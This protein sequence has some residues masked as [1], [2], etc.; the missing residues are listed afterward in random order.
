MGGVESLFFFFLED[1]VPCSSSVS[2]SEP[3]ILFLEAFGLVWISGSDVVSP[4]SRAFFFSFFGFGIV[5][6]LSI[7]T[8]PLLGSEPDA[9]GVSRAF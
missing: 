2:E 5:P 9:T 7:L 4:D 3:S 8:I 1:L 6:F